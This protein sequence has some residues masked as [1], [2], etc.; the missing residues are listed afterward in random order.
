MVNHE[1]KAYLSDVSFTGLPTKWSVKSHNSEDNISCVV[2]VH[3]L[4]AALYTSIGPIV[5]EL[6]VKCS[7]N[8]QLHKSIGGSLAFE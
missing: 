8:F 2:L 4:M 1:R 6:L 3:R 5:V 7:T